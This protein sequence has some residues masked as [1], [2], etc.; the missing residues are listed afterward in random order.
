MCD[1]MCCVTASKRPAT[2]VVRVGNNR[3]D[4]GVNP[5]CARYTGF[6]EEGRP[7]FLPCTSTMPGAFASIHLEAPPTGAPL[8]I[9]EAYV[10]TDQALPV[11]RCPGFRD[12]PLANVATYNGKCY[13]FYPHRPLNFEA[14]LRFCESRGGSLIDETSPAL[15]GFLSWELYRRHRNDPGAQYWMGAVRDPRDPSNWRW[16]SGCNYEVKAMTLERAVGQD[17]TISFWNAPGSNENCS[18]FDGSKGWLW[19]DTNCNHKLNYICQHQPSSCG[20]PERPPNST[21][22]LTSDRRVSSVVEYRCEPGHL[23]VGAASRTCLP[24]GFYTDLPP[25]CSYIEC[26]PPA[27]I[28]HGG[29][30]FPNTTRYY[31]SSVQ[32]FCQQGY[33]L[34]GEGTLICDL[35][36][37]W[38]GPPPR[39]RAVTCGPPVEI[40][41]GQATML[42]NSTQYGA[43][44]KYGCSPGHL[45]VGGPHLVC[46]DT[47]EWEGEPPSCECE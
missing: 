23:L 36:R 26:G 47:G 41:N 27:T 31:L 8:S 38:N 44:V 16:L 28:Q 37:K 14:A 21:V 42:A 46:G 40:E 39:C 7:L 25:K 35:D 20:H 45:L 4:L 15:Q 17:V 11:E 24:S 33:V 6:I 1:N 18:R 19:A 43:V 2:V 29:Y 30:T 10:Y 32:Y 12:Q 9:C 22:S 3:P 34:V 5:I 13:H